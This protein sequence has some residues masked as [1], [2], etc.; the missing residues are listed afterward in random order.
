MH[1]LDYRLLI[2]IRSRRALQQ[3]I[4]VCKDA[5]IDERYVAVT[6]TNNKNYMIMMKIMIIMTIMN[7]NNNLLHGFIFP[8]PDIDGGHKREINQSVIGEG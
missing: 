5:A 3:F 1:G 7:D 4:C 6:L 2:L 8:S